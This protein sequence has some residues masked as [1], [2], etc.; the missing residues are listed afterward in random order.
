MGQ[1][2]AFVLAPL[3]GLGWGL[4]PPNHSRSP[5]GWRRIR[6]GGR[7][8]AFPTL[9]GWHLT[10]RRPGGR[11]NGQVLGAIFG[12][13]VAK[14]WVCGEKKNKK[15]KQKVGDRQRG[16]GV[17]YTRKPDPEPWVTLA[18]CQL[19]H[20]PQVKTSSRDTALKCL[21]RRDAGGL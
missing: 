6:T 8:H 2:Y 10:S 19:S 1:I 14:P 9:R 20:D 7:G 4:H 15:K 12:R 21:K 13:V 5:A 11:S 16:S 3:L 18:H 17:F